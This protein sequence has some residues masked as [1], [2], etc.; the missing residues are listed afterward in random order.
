MQV[1]C[2]L[3]KCVPNCYFASFVGRKRLY[4]RG[5]LFYDVGSHRQDKEIKNKIFSAHGQK[6]P[7]ASELAP[8]ARFLQV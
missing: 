5:S 3:I 6:N 4:N 7:A 2:K 8:L 1:T